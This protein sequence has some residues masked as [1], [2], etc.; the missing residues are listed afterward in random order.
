MKGMEYWTC[1][2]EEVKGLIEWMRKYNNDKAEDEKLKF[3][4]FDC[5]SLEGP[6][7]ALSDY[8]TEFDKQNAD[9]FVERLPK[10]TECNSLYYRLGVGENG[11]KEISEFLGTI[12]FIENWFHEKE[13]LYVTSSGRVKFDRASYNCQVLRQT[14]LGREPSKVKLKQ[15]QVRDSCMAQNIK[16][17]YGLENSKVFVWAHNAHI[18]K[19]YSYRGIQYKRM[20][21]F[22][23]DNFGKNYYNIGFVFSKGR[24]Q[25]QESKKP[26]R[27]KEYCL[28]VY[29]KNS[30][31]N[32]LAIPGLEAYFIELRGSENPL[33]NTV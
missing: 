16:W 7:S 3:Y 27:V 9:D 8:I 14:M 29:K 20:G 31:T 19:D 4:G 12:S 17:I 11:E 32:S 23:M 30:L 21:S 1:D 25:A 6:L 10:L 13:N 22:L 15:N 24:F 5:Q 26:Y 2:T 18:S 28:P 33:F